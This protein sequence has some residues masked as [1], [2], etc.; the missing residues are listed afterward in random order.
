MENGRYLVSRFRER[1][2]GASVTETKMPDLVLWK[3]TRERPLG[4]AARRMP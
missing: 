2:P 4:R 1:Y 3:T